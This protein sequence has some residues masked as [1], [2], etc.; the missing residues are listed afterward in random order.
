MGY[1]QVRGAKRWLLFS[2]DDGPNL[3]PYPL[4]HPLDRKSRFDFESPQMDMFPAAAQLHGKG[5][6]AELHA[7]D[8][9]WLP[10]HWW[11]SVQS[12]EEETVSLNFWWNPPLNLR[13]ICPDHAIVEISRD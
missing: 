5:M 7:G 4:G 3:Y 12:L 10:S 13:K 2:P 9:L 11:H 8:V 6:L 1:M